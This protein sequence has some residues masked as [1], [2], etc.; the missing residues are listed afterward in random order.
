MKF[1]KLYTDRISDEIFNIIGTMT[2]LQKL[3]GLRLNGDEVDP[4]MFTQMLQKLGK[5]RKM[6]VVCSEK[7][8]ECFK[9]PYPSLKKLKIECE[10]A[11]I[12]PKTVIQIAT[13]QYLGF[14]L[15]VH[16]NQYKYKYEDLL[17][18]IQACP[19]TIFNIKLQPEDSLLTF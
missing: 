10:S 9:N 16:W 12:D 7:F 13:H 17:K 8:L 3:T 1:L 19:K 6:K 5:L 11:T 4:E 18:I 15:R 2:N 14:R